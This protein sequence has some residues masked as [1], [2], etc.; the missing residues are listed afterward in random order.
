MQITI[1]QAKEFLDKITPED[2][3][4]IVFHN[5]PD[6]YAS[7][8]CFAEYLKEI[9]N[10]SFYEAEL[11]N[12]IKPYLEKLK[13]S[14]K[15]I[16]SDLA[17]NVINNGFEKLKDKKILYVDHH[18]KD[19]EITESILEFRTPS[20]EP[21]SLDAFLITGK[22]EFLAFL[23]MIADAGWKYSENQDY[24]NEELRKYNLSLDEAKKLGDDFGFLLKINKGE[25]KKNIELLKGIKRP[26]DFTKFEEILKPVKDELNFFIKDFENKK[27]RIGE[28]YF[29]YFDPKLCG[30]AAVINE[31]SYFNPDAILVFTTPKE[32][33]MISISARNQSGKISCVELLKKATIGFENSSSGGHVPAAGGHILKKDLEKFKE[34]LREIK[35]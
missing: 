15:I 28:I 13:D 4:A 22:E 27:E 20:Y 10:I 19:A 1:A 12:G 29:Y 14:D 8:I 17:P 34:N 26:D 6:G 9:P 2:R 11:I 30:K 32:N 23:G 35:I 16:F 3:V 7:A 24:I 18:S 5:D 25:V 31:V 33:E 21:A